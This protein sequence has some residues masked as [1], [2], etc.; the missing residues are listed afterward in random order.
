MDLNI[1]NR[2]Y[3]IAKYFTVFSTLAVN[4][5]V[6]EAMKYFLWGKELEKYSNKEG[7]K[8]RIESLNETKGKYKQ[9]LGNIGKKKGERRGR[10][11]SNANKSNKINLEIGF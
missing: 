5:S 2:S 7:V 1:V 6:V 8:G 10:A 4:Y 3:C 11:L 9:S